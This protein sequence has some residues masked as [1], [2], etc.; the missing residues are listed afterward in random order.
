MGLGLNSDPAQLCKFVDR[1][2][3]AEAAVTAGL[4]TTKGICVSSCTVGLVYLTNAGL[5]LPGN[6]QRA[7]DVAAEYC[8][9]AHRDVRHDETIVGIRDSLVLRP[10]TQTRR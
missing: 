9:R 5:N 3:P 4:H 7:G 10:R 6:G 2:L 1:R 8:R